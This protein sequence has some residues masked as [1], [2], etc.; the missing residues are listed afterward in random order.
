[1]TESVR[2]WASGAGWPRIP[3]AGDR[4]VAAASVIALAIIGFVWWGMAQQQWHDDSYTFWIAWRSNHLYPP[5]W[6]PISQYVYSPAFAQA[7]WPLTLLSWPT[8]N[9]V[10]AALQLLALVWMLGPIGAVAG[11]AFPFPSLPVSGTAVY[12][13]I[14]NGNPMI[15]TAAAIT[16][17]LTRWPGG[18]AYVLLTKVS[19][20]IGILYFAIRRQWRELGIA[21]GV[22]AAIVLVSAFFAPRPWLEWGRLLYG[23]AFNSGGV[24]ALAK[25]QFMPLPLAVRGL[26][27]LGVVAVAAWRGWLWAVPI[28]CCLALPDIH[29]GGYAVL[30]A[31]PAVWLRQ[32]GRT[33]SIHREGFRPRRA[34]NR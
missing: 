11:L 34:T 3:I 20:G 22:T 10:W 30:T 6:R 32:K 16:L 25:E 31:V 4:V 9:A 13:T 17:G 12:A 27:G 1:V 18:F 15:L 5:E 26:I 8:V 2:A 21:L 33:A 29:L 19:A 24:E 28:G 23:A 14:D 7:F